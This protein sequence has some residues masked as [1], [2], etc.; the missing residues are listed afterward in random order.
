MKNGTKASFLTKKMNMLDVQ[1]RL[2]SAVE[3]SRS[4]L[5]ASDANMM[6]R[7]LNNEVPEWDWKKLNRKATFKMK[8]TARSS[9]IIETL[10][11]LEQTFTENLA[12]ATQNEKESADA[13]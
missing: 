6:S 8:Y 5:S 9:S 11:K 13:Y 1:D 7:M 10:E 3:I 12:E 2:R 4:V